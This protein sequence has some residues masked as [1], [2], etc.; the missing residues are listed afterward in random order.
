MQH[1]A[2]S[3]V[4]TSD[5]LRRAVR[6]LGRAIL[7][8]LLLFVA[9]PLHAD[10]LGAFLLEAIEK[11]P[12]TPPSKKTLLLLTTDLGWY[13]QNMSRL[14]PEI[15]DQ[16]Q[17]LRISVVGESTRKAAE[18]LGEPADVFL[19]SGSCKPGRDIDLL[20]VGDNTAKARSS[21][22]AA[23]G[24]TTQAILAS[25]ESDQF[26]AAA[27]K[28][29]LSIPQKLGGEAMEVVTSDLPNFGYR[30]LKDALARA[31]AAQLAGDAN[32]VEL[33]EKELREAL[34]K[35]LEAQVKSS[36]RDMY[37]GASGQRFFVLN[38]LGEEDRVR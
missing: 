36:A 7:L 27:R 18:S 5:Q 4:G 33:L 16:V 26:L 1:W 31:K 10:P 23:I 32:A 15:Q 17:Q 25:Q 20:Y 29:G 12:G 2:E 37:R 9:V 8:L 11:S 13:E 38:Y 34:R 19:A 30:D 35:N 6:L 24:D 14:S 28:Q 21:I 3:L 22:D